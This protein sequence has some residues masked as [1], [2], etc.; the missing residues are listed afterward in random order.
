MR[1]AVGNFEHARDVDVAEGHAARLGDV[2]NLRRVEC[3]AL[4]VAEHG[5]TFVD[6]TAYLEGDA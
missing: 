1:P 2:A 3:Q 5:R 6:E 4:G